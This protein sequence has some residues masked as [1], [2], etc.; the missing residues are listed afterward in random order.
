[1]AARPP[2]IDGPSAAA[3][4]TPTA[5]DST[6]SMPLAPRLASTRRPERGTA[7]HSTSRTGIDDDTTRVAPSGTERTTSRATAGSV[8]CA[9]TD[10][11]EAMASPATASAWAHAPAQLSAPSGRRGRR[12]A[13]QVTG[14]HG[15]G[16]AGLGGDEGV[17]R[18]VRIEAGP[19][20]VDPHLP[21]RQPR[22][23]LPHHLRRRQ[24]AEAHHHLGGQALGHR[25]NPQEGVG[26]ADGALGR[27][28]TAA[29]GIGQDRPA[30]GPTQRHHR[31]GVVDAGAGHD[32]PPPA[33]HPRGQRV[34]ALVRQGLGLDHGLLPRATAGPARWKGRPRLTHQRLAERE[35]QVHRAAGTPQPRHRAD[36]H[37]GGQ[38]APGVVGGRVGHPGIAEVA[39]RPPEQVLLV[40]GL[41]GAHAVQLGG[42]VG[43]AHDHGHP[44]LV[45]LDHRRVQLDGRG[46]AGGEHD[47]RATGGQA[48]PE[49]QEAGGPLVVVHVQAQPRLGGQRQHHRR[50]A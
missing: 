28:P 24:G 25:R 2:P 44:G 26:V 11:T 37:L 6:P 31:G 17:E 50:R 41:R 18:T 27:D 45:G 40:D 23:P 30:R 48:Q 20:G 5:V 42:P 14:Q 16:G 33:G 39:H 46:P 43:G 12:R 47:G 3:R 10:S 9:W 7:N 15:G 49:R 22:Q 8:G 36:V 34:E 35:V 29:A 38:R 4:A 32:D 19:V 21:G 13:P 1:M